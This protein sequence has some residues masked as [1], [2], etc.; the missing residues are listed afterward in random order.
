MRD[1][2]NYYSLCIV[3]NPILRLLLG[4]TYNELFGRS[5]VHGQ[6]AVDGGWGLEGDGGAGL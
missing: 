5:G 1:I 6:L 3:G 4:T 2:T